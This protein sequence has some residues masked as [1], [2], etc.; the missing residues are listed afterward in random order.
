MSFMTSTHPL[1]AVLWDFDGTMVDTLKRN[2]SVNRRIVQEMLERPWRSIPELLS[3]EAYRKAW[4]RVTNWQSLYTEVFGL[5]DSQVEVAAAK[6]APYQ[7]EEQ[8]PTPLFEGLPDVIAGFDGLPQAV[9]SQND[10]RIIEHLLHLAGV[11]VFFAVIVGYSEVLLSRQKPAPDGLLLALDDLGV[12]EPASVLYIGDHETDMIFAANATRELAAAGRAI[13]VI[14]VAAHFEEGSNGADW[15]TPPDHRV[16]H[17]SEITQLV[18]Q[19]SAEN[20]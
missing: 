2:L 3:I 20:P 5:S 8:T 16:Y 12:E 18:S 1:K 7:L 10:R 15:K 19:L 9:V 11:D 6:W 13:D 17:P 14:S 4:R